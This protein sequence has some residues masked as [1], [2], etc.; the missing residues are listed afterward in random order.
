MKQDWSTQ[1]LPAAKA[2]QPPA[3]EL[4]WES[5]QVCLSQGV[6]TPAHP[7]PSAANDCLIEDSHSQSALM[8]EILMAHRRPGHLI[9]EDCL[10][11]LPAPAPPR[12]PTPYPL[13]AR[14]WAKP[15]GTWD[16]VVL[17]LLYPA[18]LTPLP[19]FPAEHSLNKSP[20]L[21]PCLISC[22]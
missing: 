5:K 1:S 18:S 9:S 3:E 17:S 14:N 7:T 8:V 4:S 10:D 2:S 12:S 21:S 6:H 15:K 16:H 13:P 20:T 19:V 11:L 22:L